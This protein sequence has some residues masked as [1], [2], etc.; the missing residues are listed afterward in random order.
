MKLKADK[1]LFFLIPVIF[2]I[3]VYGNTFGNHLVLDDFRVI[4]NNVFVTSFKYLPFYLKGRITSDPA[5]PVLFRPLWMITYNFNYLISK[6]SVWSY[7][8]LNIFIHGLN[9]FLLYLLFIT[10]FQNCNRTLAIFFSLLFIAHPVNTEAVNYLSSRADLLITTFVIC[11]LI[12]FLRWIRRGEK[13][14]LFLSCFFTLL[15]FL[16]KEY[17]VIVPVLILLILVRYKK[18]RAQ[19]TYLSLYILITLIAGFYYWVLH[20]GATANYLSQDLLLNFLLQLRVG[21]LYLKLFFYPPGVSIYHDVT[22]FTFCGV[23]LALLGLIIIFLLWLRFRNSDFLLGIILFW[24]LLFPKV[25]VSLNFPA[26]ERH[27]YLPQI[28]IWISLFSIFSRLNF[29]KI[30][31]A[32]LFLLVILSYFTISRN[33]IWKS[34]ESLWLDALR[35]YPHSWQAQF[36]LGLEY[37]KEKKYESA[38]KLLSSSLKNCNNFNYYPKI[39][40][41]IAECYWGEGD[42]KKSKQIMENIYKVWPADYDFLYSLALMYD[43]EGDFK[44]AEKYYLEVTKINPFHINSFFN[45]GLLYLNN[46]NYKKAEFYFKRCLY[47]NPSFYQAYLNLGRIYEEEGKTTLAVISYKKALQNAP[48][49]AYA[50]LALGSLYAKMKDKRAEIFL[51]RAVEIKP[52]MAEA[53]YNLGLFYLENSEIKKASFC[54]EKARELGFKIPEVITVE[55]NEKK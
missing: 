27:F 49:S 41:A 40:L 53:W 35:K 28:G 19:I 16:T 48:S 6:Y 30:L 45:L 23:S 43:Q 33:K 55:L 8:L 12:T 2:V 10:L 50:N 21:F 18:L 29:K 54:L 11:V 24:I 37:L 44:S 34:G 36:C 4:T 42:Y 20:R 9:G 47:L 22:P 17:A 14:F 15:A 5:G 1:L 31:P 25:F 46:H 32:V 51:K 39:V 7:R 26:M 52:D 13:K 38:K 3:L